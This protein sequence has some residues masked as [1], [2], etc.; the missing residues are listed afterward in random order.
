MTIA[1]ENTPRILRKKNAVELLALL[2]LLVS[3]S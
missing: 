3:L 1:C 2:L